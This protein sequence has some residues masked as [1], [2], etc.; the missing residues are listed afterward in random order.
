MGVG[1]SVF[2]CVKLFHLISVIEGR[3]PSEILGMSR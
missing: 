3:P 1:V 2:V